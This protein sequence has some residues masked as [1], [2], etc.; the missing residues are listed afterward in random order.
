[1]CSW[2]IC[3][4]DEIRSRQHGPESQRKVSNIVWNQHHKELGL[5][6]KEAL[7]SVIIVFIM[8][9]V[10]YLWLSLLLWL[11]SVLIII[12]VIIISFL[13]PPCNFLLS[14]EGKLK[15][16][17]AHGLFEG[18]ERG[19]GLTCPAALQCQPHLNTK[20]IQSSYSRDFSSQHVLLHSDRKKNKEVIQCSV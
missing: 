11:L 6:Q 16:M 14:S 9:H 18:S 17:E 12:S 19:H 2:K 3:R 4:N 7:P 5:Q 10:W 20:Q 15:Q 8:N 13:R 1:M